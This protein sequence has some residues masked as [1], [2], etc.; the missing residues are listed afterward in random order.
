M[1]IQLIGL[2]EVC[3]GF[4]VLRQLYVK[5][6]PRHEEVICV[7]LQRQSLSEDV[8]S[9]L[10]RF[11]RKAN[12]REIQIQADITRVEQQSLSQQADCLW[13]VTAVFIRSRC[14]L[15]RAWIHRLSS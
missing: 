15:Q 11:M 3:F 10:K 1:W 2:L 6:A 12:G 5:D 8:N 13:R 14:Q 7:G 9:N 4:I